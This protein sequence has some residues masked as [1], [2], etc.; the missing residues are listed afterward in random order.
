MMDTGDADPLLSPAVA[1]SIV[2]RPCR[3]TLHPGPLGQSSAGLPAVPVPRGNADQPDPDGRAPLPS[4]FQPTPERGS[5]PVSHASP[6]ISPSRAVTIRG[7]VRAAVERAWE[8]A[9]ASGALPAMPA[10]ADR[11]P[12]EVERPADP[13]HG[14][15]A[16][17]LAMKLARPYRMAPL[18][19]AAALA[20]ELTAEAATTR[21][22]PIAAAEVARARLPQPPA[23]RRRAGD[24]RR[25]DPGR[26]VELGPDRGRGH[27]SLR[28]RRVR[29][30]QPD[31][32]APRRQRPRRVHRRPAQP[33]PRGGRPARHARVLLQRFRRPDPQPRRV[34][35][36]APSR[37]AGPGGRATTATTSQ[38]L[39]AAVPGRRLGGGH[40][41]GRR[42]GRHRSVTGRPAASARG[43]RP[44]SPRSASASMSGRA[45]RGCTTR[46]G[47]TGRS[48]GC[49]NAATST[50]RTARSGSAR[51]TSATTRTG[52]SSARPASRPTS[53]RT[54]ATSPRSSAAA[55]TT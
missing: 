37:R 54:S 15:F 11:P 30:G 27:G 43:S 13:V 14:D 24:D 53:R 42:Y 47:S 55:S 20:A 48:S 16:S 40:G 22:S 46:A 50:S 36:R 51:P 19:I 26:P 49:A 4:A 10:D 23:P 41:A 32:T 5:R 34:R 38:D 39:A 25:G 33:R 7:V 18:A 8:R 35:G 6:H 45:R 44:A 28:Q 1:R 21:P 52:S 12:V 17:N 29:L 31:R 9:V 3:A 2:A